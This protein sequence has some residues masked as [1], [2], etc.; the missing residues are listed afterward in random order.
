MIN[1]HVTKALGLI[2]QLDTI[3]QDLAKKR[4]NLEKDMA[5]VKT[6]ETHAQQLTGDLNALMNYL[7]LSATGNW[8]HSERRNSFLIELLRQ[9]S[10]PSEVPE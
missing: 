9:A 8:G 10:T 7:D 6:L 3:T 5:D 1:S 4:K 2:Q